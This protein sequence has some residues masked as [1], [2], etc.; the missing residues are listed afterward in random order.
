MR[1]L[2]EAAGAALTAY[3][4][5]SYI[6]R[7]RRHEAELWHAYRTLDRRCGNAIKEAREAQSELEHFRIVAAHQA[8]E[9]TQAE[10]PRLGRLYSEIIR[11]A[12]RKSGQHVSE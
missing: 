10:A 9:L 4:V 1:T 8:R 3:L 11:N 7:T 2:I 5:G 6:K 12:P